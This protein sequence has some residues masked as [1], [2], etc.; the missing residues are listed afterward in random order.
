[1]NS[2]IPRSSSLPVVIHGLHMHV[3]ELK[4]LVSPYLA[5]DRSVVLNFFTFPTAFIL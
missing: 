3:E 2:Y 4:G 5:L 1:M